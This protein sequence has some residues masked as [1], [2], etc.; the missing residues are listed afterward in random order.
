MTHRPGARGAH[1]FCTRTQTDM[2]TTT[3]TTE[4]PIIYNDWSIKRILA[5]EKHQT[6]RLVK[7]QPRQNTDEVHFKVGSDGIPFAYSCGPNG[8]ILQEWRCKYGQPGDVLWIREAFRLIESCDNL[9][10]S[11]AGGPVKYCADGTTNTVKGQSWGRKRPSIHMP[12]KLS[13]IRLRV[14]DVRVERVQEITPRDVKAEGVDPI[15]GGI[16]WYYGPDSLGFDK[17]QEAFQHVWEKIH[18]DGAWE[19][20]PWVWV[21]EFSRIE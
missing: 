3:E 17:P 12:K 20:D 6:R 18:G 10:P 5:G 15:D 7:P 14:E 11:E 4:H 1:S 13:R 16:E 21:V 2:T 9:P 8:G 19:E